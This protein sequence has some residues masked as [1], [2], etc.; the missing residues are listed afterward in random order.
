MIN[1]SA[2]A[3][4]NVH[5]ESS[6]LSGICSIL[7]MLFILHGM[8]ISL[9]VVLTPSDIQSTVRLVDGAH[10]DNRDKSYS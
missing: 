4:A 3:F 2:V 5:I 7:I 10:D 1:A 9:V 6:V 8:E